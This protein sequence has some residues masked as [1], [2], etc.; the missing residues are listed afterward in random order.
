MQIQ[1]GQVVYTSQLGGS[2]APVNMTIG[3]MVVSDGNWHNVTVVSQYRSLRLMVDGM[4]VGDELDA[5]GVHD[6]LDP[7]LTLL[8]LGGAR[9]DALHGLDFYSNGNLSFLFGFDPKFLQNFH[10]TD[11]KKLYQYKYLLNLSDSTASSPIRSGDEKVLIVVEFKSS[12]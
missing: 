8:S 11:R 10:Y 1:N 9:R 12:I 5:A 4:K 6:F 3:D 2:A 7:Y